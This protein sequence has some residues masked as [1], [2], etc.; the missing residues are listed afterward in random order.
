M[1]EIPDQARVVIIGGG[2][3]GASVAYHLGQLGVSDAVLLERD[4]YTCGTTW[5]A[6][7]LVGQLRAT[8]NLTRLCR[9]SLELYSRLE[10][11]TGQATGFRQPGALAVATTEERFVEL[12]RTAA[13]AD[14]LGVD[15]HVL[16]PSEA[17]ALWPQM[18]IGD[19][20]GA[21]HIPN[22]AMVSPVDTTMALLAG[23]RAAGVGTLQGV[24]VEELLVD[25]G[26]VAGVRTNQG[27]VRAESVVL[28]AGMWSR[29][30]AA[31]HGVPL[32]L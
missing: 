15:A 6:A 21:V 17:H 19:V 5:H 31:R 29:D 24:V 32:P 18:E 27:A 8:E 12:R 3:V 23:A 26:R 1:A 13:V 2:I 10:A 25:A 14:H 4:R 16:T 20:V 28:A 11:E 9:Y 7:G 30:F 22:D